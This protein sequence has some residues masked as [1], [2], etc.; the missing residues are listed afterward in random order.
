[1]LVNYDD[2]EWELDLDEM[3][4]KQARTIKVATGLTPLELQRGMVQVDPDALVGLF[5]YMQVTNGEKCD[6]R[7][8]NFKLVKFSNAISDA[9]V[10]GMSDEDR[11]ELEEA[12]GVDLGSAEKDTPK[13]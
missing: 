8:V 3:D 9:I 1:M 2:R 6:I 5:W 12:T 10:N 13:E 4:V 11:A 7:R